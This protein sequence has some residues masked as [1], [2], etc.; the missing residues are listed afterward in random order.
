MPDKIEKNK[1]K[2]ISRLVVNIHYY[3]MNI[4]AELSYTTTFIQKQTEFILCKNQL[5]I[6]NLYTLIYQQ[7]E[8]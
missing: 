8:K 2:L 6:H 5:Y 7:F 4:L 1:N 3:M